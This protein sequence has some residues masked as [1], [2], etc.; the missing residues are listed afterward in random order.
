MNAS[1]IEE[2][3]S[4]KRPRGNGRQETADK[5]RVKEKWATKSGRQEMTNRKWTIENGRRKKAGEHR[6]HVAEDLQD[7]GRWVDKTFLNVFTKRVSSTKN[8]EKTVLG[9]TLNNV[10]CTS[11]FCTHICSSVAKLVKSVVYF[12]LKPRL[13][14]H[15]SMVFTFFVRRSAMA[16][17]QLL[18]DEFLTRQKKCPFVVVCSSGEHLHSLVDKSGAGRSGEK[19]NRN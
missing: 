7:N 12:L 10:G 4:K 15:I 9:L 8:V 14:G 17:P 1:N 3:A 19:S 5:K 11:S 13:R 2:T 18:L 16:I 6:G